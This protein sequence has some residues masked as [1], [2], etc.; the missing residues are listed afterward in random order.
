MFAILA[1]AERL[2]GGRLD[3]DEVFGVLRGR[4]LGP[5]SWVEH[6]VDWISP[7]ADQDFELVKMCY[8]SWRRGGCRGFVTPHLRRRH[9]QRQ[10]GGLHRC[11]FGGVFPVVWCGDK[12]DF[13]MTFI[14]NL[15][16]G[17]RNLGIGAGAG[18]NAGRGW[19]LEGR[20]NDEAD[21]VPLAAFARPW[22]GSPRGTGR[23]PRV[24]TS[25]PW[26]RVA[27]RVARPEPRAERN[28]SSR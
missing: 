5:R 14:F 16:N 1:V 2:H 3:A 21:H 12:L 7:I 23:R 20:N 8:C 9:C 27:R 19:Q 11:L 17:F 4:L 25:T 24:E 6:F 22:I 10:D 18:A 26:G 13:G 28:K 15:F